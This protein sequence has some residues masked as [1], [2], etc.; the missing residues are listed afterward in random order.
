M[1]LQFYCFGKTPCYFWVT[2]G[3]WFNY[4]FVK[5]TAGYLK[6]NIFLQ[7][8]WKCNIF[9]LVEI[10][11][12]WEAVVL[13][14]PKF[15][16]LMGKIMNIREF[17]WKVYFVRKNYA[18]TWLRMVLQSHHIKQHKMLYHKQKNIFS[19]RIRRR[20]PRHW[21]N[22]KLNGRIKFPIGCNNYKVQ[23]CMGHSTKL[24]SRY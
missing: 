13:L 16:N 20:I 10:W 19:K 21:F 5:K 18:C 23:A 9:L 14:S 8:L 12:V 3:W 7:V 22:T 1:W 6:K 24:L 4:I 17:T 15:H 11:Q 2:C